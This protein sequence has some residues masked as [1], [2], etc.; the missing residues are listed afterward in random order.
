MRLCSSS[1]LTTMTSNSLGMVVVLKLVT[2]EAISWVRLMLLVEYSCSVQYADTHVVK[3][4][5][6]PQK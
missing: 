6:S 1:F 5:N 2:N 4:I 3:E